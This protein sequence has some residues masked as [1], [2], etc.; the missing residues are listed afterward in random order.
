MIA[1]TYSCPRITS[2]PP[3]CPSA[4]DTNSVIAPT[5]SSSH[6]TTSTLQPT[7]VPPVP[8]EPSGSTVTTVA[9]TE[10]AT[11]ESTTTGTVH[12][13]EDFTPPGDNFESIS[14]IAPTLTNEP[15]E[16]DSSLQKPIFILPLIIGLAAPLLIFSTIIVL[17]TVSMCVYFRAKKKSVYVVQ[18]LAYNTVHSQRTLNT[19]ENIQHVQASV[20]NAN[21]IELTENDAYDVTHGDHATTNEVISTEKN[22]AYGAIVSDS[23]NCDELL[24]SYDY[25]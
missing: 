15:V 4:T 17:L 10:I 13:T 2:T 20:D 12:V 24:E 11:E 1:E 7:S 16:N 21:D 8:I 14:I 25:I 22:K 9:T 6:D 23:G 3:P 19:E 18:N 5:S